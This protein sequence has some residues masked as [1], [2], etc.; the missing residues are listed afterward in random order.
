[1]KKTNPT[2][3]QLESVLELYLVKKAPALPE[4]VKEIIVKY[5]P[6]L[7][8]LGLVLS[9]PSII[10]LLGLGG[11]IN[12]YAYL[13]GVYYGPSF[14]ISVIFLV[15]STVLMG[16]SIPGLFAR[17]VSAWNLMF[18]SSLVNAV[19]NLIRFDLGS[20]IIGAAISLY[21]LFQVKSYYR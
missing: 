18:Y 13:S 16:L 10:T 17:K 8:I 1:M 15:I 6:Y 11:L 21:F 20:L 4:N 2:L 19:Y 5:S 9:V 3:V 14:S 12:R 7:A